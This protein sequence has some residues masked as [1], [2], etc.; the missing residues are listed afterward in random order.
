MFTVH[1][2]FNVLCVSVQC[3]IK[4]TG[5]KAYVFYITQYP[6]RAV[7]SLRMK[8]RDSVVK[9]EETSVWDRGSAAGRERR[10]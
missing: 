4:K 7:L 1:F 2:Y 3:Y 6:L 10:T 8:V 9:G 5:G